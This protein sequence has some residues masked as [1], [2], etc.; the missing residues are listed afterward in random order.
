MKSVSA[1]CDWLLCC[2]S[3]AGL[4]VTVQSSQGQRYNGS[5]IR[6]AQR[7]QHHD[8]KQPILVVFTDD[9]TTRRPNFVS[10]DDQGK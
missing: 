8:S 7:H 10:P 4:L 5:Y 3:D 6:F 1:G 9:G 2:S